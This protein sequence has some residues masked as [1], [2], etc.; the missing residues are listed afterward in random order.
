[1]EIRRTVRE[2]GGFPRAREKFWLRSM[3]GLALPE[4]LL[5]LEWLT[6]PGSVRMILVG[7][8]ALAILALAFVVSLPFVGLYLA[9][10][11]IWYVYF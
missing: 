1:M 5:A 8:T 7:K 11:L 2:T 6:G 4:L 10:E 3:V 9:Y